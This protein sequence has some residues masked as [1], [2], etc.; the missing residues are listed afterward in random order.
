MLNHSLDWNRNWSNYYWMLSSVKTKSFLVVGIEL[1]ITGAEKISLRVFL[2]VFFFLI[3]IGRLFE[4]K[5]YFQKKN[6]HFVSA[7]RF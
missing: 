4:I 7:G 1:R 5:T 6:N 3:N 2:R